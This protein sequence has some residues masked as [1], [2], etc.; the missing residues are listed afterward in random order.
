[1]L[2]ATFALPITYSIDRRLGGSLPRKRQTMTASPYCE[3]LLACW[4]ERPNCQ[5]IGFHGVRLALSHNSLASSSSNHRNQ[6]MASSAWQ[7]ERLLCMRRMARQ[8][9]GTFKLRQAIPRLN[10]FEN[11]DAKKARATRRPGELINQ[12]DPQSGGDRKSDQWDAGGPLVVRYD[13]G[14]RVRALAG[15]FPTMKPTTSPAR[16]ILL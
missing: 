4:R 12:I 3:R 13:V 5:Q 6:S 8:R 1:M 11:G 10:A 15:K 7:G 9:C 14:K 2:R 16:D